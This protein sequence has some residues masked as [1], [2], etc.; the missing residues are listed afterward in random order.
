LD[1]HADKLFIGCDGIIIEEGLYT[2]D[3]YLSSIDEKMVTIAN[4]VFLV[5]DSSKFG[6]KSFVKYAAV[7]AVDTIITDN[8]VN[9]GIVD[10]LEDLG[11]QVI[12]VD[13]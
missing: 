13:L 5:T 2:S 8:K 11:V 4:E 7:N 9:R 12:L 3:L 1:F 6:R 10:Q